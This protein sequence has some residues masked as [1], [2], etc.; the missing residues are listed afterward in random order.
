MVK[1]QHYSTNVTW[2]RLSLSWQ[3]WEENQTYSV[4]RWHTM[5]SWW[6]KQGRELCCFFLIKF[7]LFMTSPLTVVL[8]CDANHKKC[9]SV[10]LSHLRYGSHFQ[11]L[12]SQVPRWDC[13]EK[14]FFLLWSEKSVLCCLFLTLQD[15]HSILTYTE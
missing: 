3:K 15:V 8:C 14:I 4:S 5:F 1:R 11:I 6:M 10:F 9:Y 13:S 7:Q 12:I 2:Y